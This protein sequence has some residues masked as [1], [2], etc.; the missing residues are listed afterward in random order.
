MESSVGT[1]D[2]R[3]LAARGERGRAA[4][5]EEWMR[6]VSFFG[7]LACA[8]VGCSREE[9]VER[10]IPNEP[11]AQE[12]T[13]TKV[14]DSGERASEA[15]TQERPVTRAVP[16]GMRAVTVELPAAH[17][18]HV[19][20]G[21][22]VYMLF[23]FD[24]RWPSSPEDEP[25]VVRGVVTHHQDIEVSAVMCDDGRCALTLFMPSE[26]AH[27]LLALWA[28]PDT[29]AH[30]WVLPKGEHER[31]E[32]HAKL[33]KEVLRE[34]DIA[35]S[36]YDAFVEGGGVSQVRCTISLEVDTSPRSV[37]LFE[38]GA[39][40]ELI[41]SFDTNE[42]DTVSLTLLQRVEVERARVEGDRVV[43]ELDVPWDV[44]V[45]L[46]VARRGALRLDFVHAPPDATHHETYKEFGEEVVL[47]A[48]VHDTGRPV[49]PRKP[50][51]P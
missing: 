16:E 29:Q 32:T 34:V 26:A 48:I 3:G 50:R 19:E 35:Q 38:G 1:P 47:D 18:G 6:F 37:S 5:E 25:P 20:P 45:S 4:G 7:V 15:I 40:G 2:H 39:F 51:R 8:L 46:L 12:D 41:G 33:L 11:V 14:V 21:A 28:R 44:A 27:E 30:P 17:A 9:W 13:P 36:S 10:Q 31:F 43:L 42:G 49:R 22:F 24:G 23:T